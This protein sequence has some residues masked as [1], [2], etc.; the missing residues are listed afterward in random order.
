MLGGFVALTGGATEPF[1][2]FADILGDAAP[3]FVA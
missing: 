2:G 1:D 3:G